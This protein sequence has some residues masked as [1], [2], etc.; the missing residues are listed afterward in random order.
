[1]VHLH[2]HCHRWPASAGPQSCYTVSAIAAAASA[3]AMFTWLLRVGC[4][5]QGLRQLDAHHLPLLVGK[6]LQ[7][8]DVLGVQV[9][10]APLQLQ[11]L[12]R[13]A[14]CSAGGSV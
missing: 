12:G 13:P 14:A 5:H 10:E 11:V 6:L 4:P 3:D 1:M 2:G 8:G 9:A 7:L